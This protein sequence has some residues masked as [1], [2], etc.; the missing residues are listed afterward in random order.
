[1]GFKMSPGWGGT[2]DFEL[3]GHHSGCRIIT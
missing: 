2:A 3:G 1:L